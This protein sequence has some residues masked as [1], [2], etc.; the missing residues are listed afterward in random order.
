MGR[1]DYKCV[2][3]YRGDAYHGW[4]RQ[5][6]IMTVQGMIEFALLK[7]FGGEIKTHGASRTDAGVHA[8]G[9]VFS[10][11]LETRIPAANIKSVLNDLLPPDIRVVDCAEREGFYARWN[12]R[13]KFYRYLINNT[14]VKYPFYEGLCWQL[15]RKPD[16]EKMKAA[17]QLFKGEKNYKAF[18]NSGIQHEDFIRTVDSI[19]IN[20]QGKLIIIDFK[21]KSFLY[22]MIRKITG[23]L[24]SHGLNELSA[25]EIERMFKTGDRSI[26]RNMAPPDGLYLVKIIYKS[27]ESKASPDSGNRNPEAREEDEE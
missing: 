27:A 2:V 19:N 20:K 18:S 23:A 4:Q 9:Q 3:S 15:D 12:V 13:K 17:G 5:P 6:N 25:N 10:F 8:F 24:V 21:A 11:Q 22:N 7:F 1:K 14:A 16:I 26:N